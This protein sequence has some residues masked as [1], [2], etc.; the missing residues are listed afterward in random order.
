M[1]FVFVVPPLASFSVSACTTPL[2]N[3]DG[4]W[5]WSGNGNP[6]GSSINLT[7]VTAGTI[8]SG[9]GG[10]CG[11]GPGCTPGTVTITGQRLPPSAFRITLTGNGDWAAIYSDQLVGNDSL[12]GTW[13][14]GAQT[15]TATLVR[16]SAKPALAWCD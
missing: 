2:P 7:L 6:G 5:G 15:N 16:C 11:I 3:L 13:T 4:K 10:I 8:V 1:R 12:E 14:L 9:S